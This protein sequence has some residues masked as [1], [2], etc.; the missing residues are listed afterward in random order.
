MTRSCRWKAVSLCSTSLPDSN[1][2]A[3]TTD[4]ATTPKTP[5]RPRATRPPPARRRRP[6]ETTITEHPP[7]KLAKHKAKY[8]FVSDEA[9]SS[10][11][12]K[13]DKKPFKACSSPKKVKHLDEGKHK[14]KV[15]AVDA[16]GNV[17][18]TPAKDKFKVAG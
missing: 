1:P 10:F 13:I 12:C 3:T 6:P 14:F 4:W 17:D 9:G 16:A 15:R 11:Q 2:T 8:R 18:S 7:N 5:I